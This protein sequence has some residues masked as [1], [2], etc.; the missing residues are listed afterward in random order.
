[1]VARYLAEAGSAQRLL[2]RDAGRAPEFEVAVPPV[3]SYANWPGFRRMCGRSPG[4]I[5]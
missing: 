3:F 2:V 1:M 5:R 4:R